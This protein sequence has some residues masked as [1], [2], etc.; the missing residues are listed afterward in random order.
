METSKLT[1]AEIAG[2]QPAKLKE[3]ENEIR[4]ELATV[5]MDL[6]TAKSSHRGKI[7]KLKKNLARIMTVQTQKRQSATKA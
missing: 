2:F 5:R 1:M 4:R 6:Y 7:V 3:T